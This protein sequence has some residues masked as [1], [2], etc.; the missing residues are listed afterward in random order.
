MTMTSNWIKSKKNKNFFT[1]KRDNI[2][3]DQ[4]VSGLFLEPPLLKHENVP[5]RFGGN[6]TNVIEESKP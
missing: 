2:N 4:E 5:Y 1:N 6:E 3:F